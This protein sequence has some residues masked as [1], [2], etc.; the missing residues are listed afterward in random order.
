M[1]EII[2]EF[3]N[4]V[5]LVK[6]QG[7]NVLF[8]NT[9]FGA[10]MAD[11][12]GLKLDYDGVCREFPDLKDHEDW[13]G[14]AIKRFKEKIESMESEEEIVSYLVGDLRKQGYVP[15]FKQKQGFRREVINV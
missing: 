12:S 6:V 11:I 4:E 15:K 7:K 2:F 13:R 3:G 5:I 1:I 8:G 9:T 10:Q 14:E